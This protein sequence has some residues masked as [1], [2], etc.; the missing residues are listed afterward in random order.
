MIYKTHIGRPHNEDAPTWCPFYFQQVKEDWLSDAL[1]ITRESTMDLMHGIPDF[2]ENYRYQPGKWSVKS[3]LIHLIDTERYYAFLALCSSRKIILDL[4]Q[5][6]GQEFFALNDHSEEKTIPNIAAEFAAVRGATIALF[7][8]LTEDMLDYKIDGGPNPFT[9]RSIGW[10]IAG[11]T[12]HHCR[13][14]R[15][16]YLCTP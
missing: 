16:K 14:L 1:A 10:T 7:A 4:N 11:H 5:K 12:S 3:V 6:K 2:K 9:T 13:I 15:E 8:N